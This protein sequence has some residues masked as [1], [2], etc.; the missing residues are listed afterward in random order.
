MAQ[1]GSQGDNVFVFR[2]RPLA[3]GAELPGP[4]ARAVAAPQKGGLRRV[5]PP[6]EAGGW[7]QPLRGWGNQYFARGPRP[8]TLLPGLTPRECHATAGEGGWKNRRAELT[9]APKVHGWCSG[10]LS[11][12]LRWPLRR[13]DAEHST[14]D[15]LRQ[16]CAAMV[17]CTTNSIGLIQQAK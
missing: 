17:R 2:G 13:H 5:S 7:G 6:E 14:F 1:S 12:K 3:W 9:L 16:R 8:G 10:G 11:A 15:G 4:L